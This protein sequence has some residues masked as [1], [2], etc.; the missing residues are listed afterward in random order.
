MRFELMIFS[1]ARKHSPTEPRVLTNEQE[2]CNRIWTCKGETPTYCKQARLPIP[3]Y[4]PEAI[5]IHTQ[6][7]DAAQ[8]LI[9]MLKDLYHCDT[10]GYH[11]VTRLVWAITSM[12][13]ATE[14][15]YL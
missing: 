3:P 2:G 8:I 14:D 15:I 9:S 12:V 7:D 10:D 13:S 4:N 5:R 6:T 1:L 11:P